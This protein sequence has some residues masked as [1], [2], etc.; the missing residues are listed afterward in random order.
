MVCDPGPIYNHIQTFMKIYERCHEFSAKDICSVCMCVVC[1]C[2]E[3]KDKEMPPHSRLKQI[4]QTL[5]NKFMITPTL[6]KPFK[7]RKQPKFYMCT[8]EMFGQIVI[9]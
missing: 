3:I 7:E 4:A 1:V 9:G 5:H 8:I 6:N 2:I